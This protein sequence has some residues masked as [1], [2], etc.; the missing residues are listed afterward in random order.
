MPYTG[1]ENLKKANA[2]RKKGEKKHRH[3]RREERIELENLY[4]KRLKLL[5]EAGEYSILKLCEKFGVSKNTVWN[6]TKVLDAE[7]DYTGTDPYTMYQNRIEE[8]EEEVTF[9]RQRL[10]TAIALTNTKADK[11]VDYIKRLKIELQ[12]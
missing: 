5:N 6:M 3:L 1:L 2:A 10:S 12:G 7:H 8:L 11:L 4:L 9:L